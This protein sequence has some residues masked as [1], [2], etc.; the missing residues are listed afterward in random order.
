MKNFEYLGEPL[1]SGWN[2]NGIRW[3]K[4][5]KVWIYQKYHKGKKYSKTFRTK[6]EAMVCKFLYM[7]VIITDNPRVHH[8]KQVTQMRKLMW[9]RESRLGV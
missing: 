5:Q 3:M 6:H 1:Y 9:E 8:T 4:K 7:M 2:Y